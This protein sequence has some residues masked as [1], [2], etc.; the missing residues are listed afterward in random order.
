MGWILAIQSKWDAFLMSRLSEKTVSV[1]PK[2]N[3]TRNCELICVFQT[4]GAALA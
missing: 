1:P 4:G 3:E 2:I